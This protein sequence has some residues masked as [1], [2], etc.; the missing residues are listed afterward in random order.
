M[1]ALTGTIKIEWAWLIESASVCNYGTYRLI[2]LAVT[3]ALTIIADS[4]AVLA[5][6]C[7]TSLRREVKPH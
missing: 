7:L 2:L 3:C 1:A 6:T 5:T 4:A